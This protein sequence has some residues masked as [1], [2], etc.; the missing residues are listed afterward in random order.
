MV[1]LLVSTYMAYVLL[2]VTPYLDKVNPE[3]AKEPL[4]RIGLFISYILICYLLLSGTR[5]GGLLH[6]S[7][8]KGVDYAKNEYF[9]VSFLASSSQFHI[10]S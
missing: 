4:L 3:S 2:V 8:M 9:V 1:V 6:F 5:V 7:K 10:S